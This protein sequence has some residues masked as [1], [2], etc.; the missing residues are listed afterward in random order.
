LGVGV[1]PDVSD[2]QYWP[3]AG[4]GSYRYK[5]RNRKDVA[6]LTLRPSMKFNW[7]MSPVSPGVIACSTPCVGALIRVTGAARCPPAAV[8]GLAGPDRPL[9]AE[10]LRQ[11]ASSH[12]HIS[13]SLRS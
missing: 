5:C 7:F 10:T 13:A 11:L 8:L 2:N 1:V 4:H 9:A 12:G 3:V 6:W